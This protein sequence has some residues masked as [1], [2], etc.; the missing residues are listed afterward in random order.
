[1]FDYVATEVERSIY[2][3]RAASMLDLVRIWHFRVIK[4]TLGQSSCTWGIF[5]VE[6]ATSAWCHC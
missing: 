2:S 5:A 4:L 1:M 6:V 3:N